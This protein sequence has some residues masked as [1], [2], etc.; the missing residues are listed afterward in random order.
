MFSS[1]G[2]KGYFR[3]QIQSG[4][5]EHAGHVERSQAQGLKN[6]S[7]IENMYHTVPTDN[8]LENPDDR[9]YLPEQ[10]LEE[11]WDKEER[12]ERKKSCSNPKGFTMKQFCKNQKT[13]SKKGEKKNEAK[14]KDCFDN[15]TF[16]GKV[17]CVIRKKKISK[18]RASAYVASVLRDMGELKEMVSEELDL[19]LAQLN[20]SNDLTT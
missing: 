8:N 5:E 2:T 17:R 20:N 12:E 6:V 14:E 10:E 4:D 9:P 18:D 15:K 7:E 19:V 16:G 13:R 1:S 3:I 11:K